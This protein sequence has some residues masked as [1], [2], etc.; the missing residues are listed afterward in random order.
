MDSFPVHAVST[1]LCVSRKLNISEVNF[2]PEPAIGPN[3]TKR[4]KNRKNEEK[5]W[6]SIC[7][8]LPRI[9]ELNVVGEFGI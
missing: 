1:Y 2:Q 7:P 6:K 8:T 5:D 4:K 3:V 9:G